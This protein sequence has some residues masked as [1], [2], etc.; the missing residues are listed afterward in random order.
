VRALAL[1][2][3]GGPAAGLAGDVTLTAGDV[4][5]KPEDPEPNR[6]LLVEIMAQLCAQLPILEE[7]ISCREVR[8]AVELIIDTG[9]RPDEIRALRWDCL[10]YDPDRSPFLAHD[11]HKNARLGR[12]LPI[13]EGTAEAITAQKDWV[14]ALFPDAH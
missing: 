12:R 2:R 7:S 9:R 6:D 11:N 13:A 14:R 3:P 1:T 4:P 5:I 8:V 10:E